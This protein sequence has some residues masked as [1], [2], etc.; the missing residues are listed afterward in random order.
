MQY[1]NGKYS[2]GSPGVTEGNPDTRGYP[3]DQDYPGLDEDQDKEINK[4]DFAERRPRKR[5]RLV[6]A[7]L[8]LLLLAVAGAVIWLMSGGQKTRVTVPV[9]DNAQRTDQA[10]ARNN[11]DVT[12]QA[13]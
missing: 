9:R 10:A 11:D 12:A 13:I 5:K 1:T 3:F 7:V 4:P 8:F 2:N 6:G